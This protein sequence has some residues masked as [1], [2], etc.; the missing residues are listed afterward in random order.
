MART[1]YTAEEI[2][3][4]LRT[5]EIEPGKGIGIA[6]A[7]RKLGLTEPTDDRGKKA[8]GAGASRKP[9]GCRAWSRSM[10]E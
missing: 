9:N 10:R 7:C 1:R 5:S 6:A 4:H 2:I 8:Y 3:G